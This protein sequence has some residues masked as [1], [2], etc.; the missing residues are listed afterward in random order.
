M[1]TVERECVRPRDGTVLAFRVHPRVHHPALI[2]TAIACAMEAVRPARGW[3]RSKNLI[4]E[5][6]HIFRRFTFLAGSH[7]LTANLPNKNLR[8]S[9]D[10]C[11]WTHVLANACVHAWT[12][13]SA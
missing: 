3:M 9:S 5:V 6:V 10:H 11:N 4:W 2:P 8:F 7:L 12:Y 1:V 13:I